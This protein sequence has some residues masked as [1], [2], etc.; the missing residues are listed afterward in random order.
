MPEQPVEAG[1]VAQDSN[2]SLL[3]SLFR[4]LRTMDNAQALEEKSAPSADGRRV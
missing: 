2:E 3:R 1:S 4:V